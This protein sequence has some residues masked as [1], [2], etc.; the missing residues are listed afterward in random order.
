MISEEDIVL[1]LATLIKTNTPTSF[2]KYGDG[3]YLCVTSNYGYNCDNDNYTNKLK[4]GIIESFKYMIDENKNENNYIGLWNDKQKSEFWKSLVQNKINWV[5]YQTFIIVDNDFK[6]KFINNDLK[7]KIS[8][9]KTI[10]DSKLNKYIICNPLMVKIG[11]LFNTENIL[12]V[13][14]QNWFDEHFENHLSYLKEKIGNDQ[15]PMVLTSCGMSAKV[16]IAELSKI[17]PKGIFLDIGSAL[18]LLCTKHDSRGWKYS[19][20]EIYDEFKCLLPE[21]WEN[22]KWNNIYIQA[23]INTG[24]HLKNQ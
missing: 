9:Y 11:L 18:D 1:K 12:H 17:Y 19:Y 21:D 20:Q 8:L 6:N 5:N 15:Q 10:Q 22:D 3:E 4:N 23:K 13:P 24:L 2:S 14:F 16:F 7:N